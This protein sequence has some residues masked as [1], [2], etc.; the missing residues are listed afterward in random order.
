MEEH[1]PIIVR[2]I[3]RG[4]GGHGGAWKVALADFT[5]AMMAF[6][7]VLWL[8]ASTTPKQKAAIEAYFKD[9]VGFISGGSP[10]PIDL[11]GSASVAQQSSADQAPRR[12]QIPQ[13]QVKSMADTL[14]RQKM[15]QLMAQIKKKIDQDKTLQKFKNQL[16]IDITDQG[17]RIQIVDSS[18]RPMFD[19]GSAEL[20]YYSEDLLFALAKPLSRIDNKI[21]ITG[22]T[23]STP[24]EGRPGYTN[25]ELSADRA[26]TAR[27]ALVAGGVRPDQIARVVGLADSVPLDSDNPRAPI[28]RRIS[29]IVLNKK[30][31]ETIQK[32][33]AGSGTFDPHKPTP[34][35]SKKAMKSLEEG[36]W[37][38]KMPG[39][40]KQSN[41]V[42]W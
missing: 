29:I 27:R 32:N 30:A 21:S 36:T 14:E 6:F 24:Y 37:F 20:K 18:G 33:A 16:L 19:S 31:A 23:D 40:T 35:Q 15:Q 38:D 17:L 11:K 25:W 4:G 34:A 7:M 12:I 3:K 39:Q 28:N 5:T 13:A 42:Q 22:H 9:P 8:T 26:N 41:G 1:Q 2:R 10:N